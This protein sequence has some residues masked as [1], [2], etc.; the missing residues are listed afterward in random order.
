M[1]DQIIIGDK[2]VN[3]LIKI[4]FYNNKYLKQLKY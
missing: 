2:L 3:I 1:K 4:N